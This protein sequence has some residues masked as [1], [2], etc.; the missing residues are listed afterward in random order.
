VSLCSA[1]ENGVPKFLL[2]SIPTENSVKSGC[3]CNVCTAIDHFHYNIVE[4]PHQY[5]LYLALTESADTVPSIMSLLHTLHTAIR[6]LLLSTVHFLHK[7]KRNWDGVAVFVAEL[8]YVSR[9]KLSSEFR[10]HFL[11]WAVC[12]DRCLL[13]S[14]L[15]GLDKYNLLHTWRAN[16]NKKKLFVNIRNKN[17]RRKGK[18]NTMKTTLQFT[19]FLGNIRQCSDRLMKQNSK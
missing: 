5:K 14:I 10:L 2:T 13:Y 19:R 9:P 15:T 8:W 6:K 3:F 12:T 16:Q 1:E 7:A 4:W 18:H 17:Y 11:L